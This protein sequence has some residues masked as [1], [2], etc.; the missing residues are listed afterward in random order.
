MMSEKVSIKTEPIGNDYV[1]EDSTLSCS[2]IKLEKF[3]NMLNDIKDEPD[4]NK[5][6][7]NLPANVDKYTIYVIKE[8]GN[9]D[10]MADVLPE[11]IPSFYTPCKSDDNTEVITHDEVHHQHG[12]QQDQTAPITQHISLP[13]LEIM[14]V[15]TDEQESKG[16]ENNGDT[17]VNVSSN[18][19]HKCELC[20]SSYA[21]VTNLRRH[22]RKKHPLS[23]D[24]KYIC[25]ICNQR[26]TSQPGLDR[27]SLQ[28]H[29]EAHTTQTPYEHKCEL[30]DSSYTENACLRRHIRDKHSSSIDLEYIC[31]IC[32]QR[33]A[34]QAGL[35]THS[36]RRHPEVQTSSK[37]KCE[38]C[39]SCYIQ[40][41]A[42]LEHMKNKHP[43][44]I[45]LEFICEICNQ[46]FE[47]QAGLSTHSYRR[48]PKPQTSS[49]HT[50]KICG[51]CYRRLPALLEHMRNKHPSSIGTEYRCEICNQKFTTQKGLGIHSYTHTKTPAKYNCEICG[52]CYTD[53]RNLRKHIR[54]KH[55]L[56]IDTEYICEICKQRFTTKHGLD[57]HCIKM[58]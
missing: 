30:C 39:G 16:S 14:D 55:P 10:G 50:C 19:E 17:D 15:D 22:M 48:H 31:D 28:V 41:P 46:R 8:E 47:T 21:G 12:T 7:E 58:H 44:P 40:L 1:Q 53:D 32:N 9:G 33:F 29:K 2:T 52:R 51:S 25:K 13:K 43:S 5:M 11:D 23:I 3:T 34:T 38:I 35:C 24:S 27:H 36:Y 45:D 57:L 4:L 42:L 37:H 56:S 54:D 49:K 6:E 26:F 20:G 18:K